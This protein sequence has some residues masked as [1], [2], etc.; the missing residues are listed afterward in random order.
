MERR[1]LFWLTETML[2]RGILWLVG[3]STAKAVADT[4]RLRLAPAP[5]P[6]RLF[7]GLTDQARLILAV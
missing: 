1:H 4:G 7:A 6:S 3:L 5:F 2:N